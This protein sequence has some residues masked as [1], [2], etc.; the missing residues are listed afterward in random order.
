MG[1]MH[2]CE[3]ATNMEGHTDPHLSPIKNKLVHHKGKNQTAATTDYCHLENHFTSVVAP[4]LTK[5]VVKHCG[6][7]LLTRFMFTNVIEMI[8]GNRNLSLKKSQLYKCTLFSVNEHK[9]L[10]HLSI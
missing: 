5:G 7:Q 8:C 10:P 3:G 2:I 6:Q 1:E 9:M 4:K